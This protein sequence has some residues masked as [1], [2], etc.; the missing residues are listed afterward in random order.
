VLYDTNTHHLLVQ[1]NHHGARAA[2][3]AEYFNQFIPNEYSKSLAHFT[4]AP[5]LNHDMERKLMQSKIIT[6]LQ[7]RIATTTMTAADKHNNISLLK[8]LDLGREAEA[9]TITVTLSAGRQKQSQLSLHNIKNQIKQ[10]LTGSREDQ[11]SVLSAKVHLKEELTSKVEVVDLFKQRMELDIPI[12]LGSDRRYAVE[13]RWQAL[14]DARNK[15]RNAINE[16]I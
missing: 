16:S 4:L 12:S 3:I 13:D 1:Y 8:A 10:L 9:E 6:Q 2:L 11:L 5:R 14:Q 15:W 7:Y